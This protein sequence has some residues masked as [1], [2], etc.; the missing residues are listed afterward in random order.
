MKQYKD[1][2]KLV[3]E[4]G[5][6]SNDRTGT[7]TRRLFGHKMA[8]D[9]SKQFP[10]VTLKYTHTPAVIH[11]LLWFIKGD[12]NIKYLQDNNVRIW[13]EWAD[14]SGEVGPMYGSQWRNSGSKLKINNKYNTD[15]V[16]QLAKAIHDIKNNPSSRRIIIDCWDPK[17]IPEDG[18]SP[19]EN[20]GIGKMALAPCHM[21]MQ[22]YVRKDESLDLLMY[23]RSVDSF[24]GLPF[25]IASYAILL[26]MVAQVSGKTPGNFI[27]VGGDVHIYNNH[28]PQVEIMLE[29]E[30]KSPPYLRLNKEISNINDFTF[31]D[32]E[33]VGYEY[34]PALKGVMLIYNF[35]KIKQ[36]GK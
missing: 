29:R 36:R 24:L 32:I 12:T 23:Q 33:I 2:I 1:L 28:I 15:G 13:N 16:D 11:E 34:H 9:C 3:Y 21:F 14:P 27:W 18:Y 6:L 20:V 25:N 22:F 19:I 31:D 35:L 4:T 5:E 26:N 30:P 17:K 7:G 10:L 8:F